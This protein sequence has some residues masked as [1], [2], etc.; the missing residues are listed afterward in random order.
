VARALPVIPDGEESQPPAGTELGESDKTKRVAS[1]K[2]MNV[3]MGDGLKIWK[4]GETATGDESMGQLNTAL[5]HAEEGA[6]RKAWKKGETYVEQAAIKAHSKHPQEIAKEGAEA[7]NKGFKMVTKMTGDDVANVEGE[8]KKAEEEAPVSSNKKVEPHGKKVIDEFKESNKLVHMAKV[9]HDERRANAPKRIAAMKQKKAVRVEKEAHFAAKLAKWAS[10]KASSDKNKQK[11]QRDTKL[12]NKISKDTNIIFKAASRLDTA[13]KKAKAEAATAKKPK[14]DPREKLNPYGYAVT[15]MEHM[16]KGKKIAK[17]SSSMQRMTSWLQLGEGKVPPGFHLPAKAEGSI[18]PLVQADAVKVLARKAHEDSVVQAAMAKAEARIH[19]EF[20]NTAKTTRSQKKV[21]K[22]V[23]SRVQKEHDFLNSLE[24][25]PKPQLLV[26]IAA[27]ARK[28]VPA[29]FRLP[30]AP[31]GSVQKGVQSAVNTAMAMQAQLEAQEEA[32]VRKVERED[33][34]RFG[35][36]EPNDMHTY[37]QEKRLNKQML[38]VTQK[39]EKEH[40]EA[41]KVAETGKGAP[42]APKAV[43]VRAFMPPKVVN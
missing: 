23:K 6:L 14:T 41:G 13:A 40:Q 19:G 36:L 5:G 20:A 15:E 12:A 7:L 9:A 25:P 38:K 37:K 42:K 30:S 4:D 10:A 18:R 33:H 22:P 43:S 27:S 28:E 2:E 34:E 35:H 21:K 29:G 24:I 11:K 3:V 32:N 1:A 31:I 8:E 16:K 39:A 26:E 17:P